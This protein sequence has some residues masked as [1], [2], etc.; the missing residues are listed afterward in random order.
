M[1]QITFLLDEGEVKQFEGALQKDGRK[2][3]DVLR[4]AVKAYVDHV[5]KN[6]HNMPFNSL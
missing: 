5:K 4:M 2:K 6:G 1:K 3:S